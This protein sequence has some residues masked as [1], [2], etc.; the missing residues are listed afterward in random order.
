MKTNILPGH[1][2]EE[3]PT[4]RE[5]IEIPFDV[6]LFFSILLTISYGIHLNGHFYI[7]GFIARTLFWTYESWSRLQHAL[8]YWYFL[9]RFNCYIMPKETPSDSTQSR[10]QQLNQWTLPETPAPD[11][12]VLMPI[13][14]QI[15]FLW[16]NSINKI[17]NIV[18][19]TAN[20]THIIPTFTSLPV[21]VNMLH[22]SDSPRLHRDNN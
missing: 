22:I 16:H 4:H 6:I 13:R 18:T 3:G 2:C 14:P 15:N 7:F 8:F 20:A 9:L 21:T 12:E 19:F 5:E 11:T 17:F 10:D 1:L